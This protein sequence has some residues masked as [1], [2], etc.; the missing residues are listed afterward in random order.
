MLIACAGCLPAW[1]IPELVRLCIT[2]IYVCYRN[3]LCLYDGIF[4]YA[5]NICLD[6]VWEKLKKASNERGFGIVEKV[7][8]SKI[9]ITEELKRLECTIL[10]LDREEREKALKAYRRLLKLLTNEPIY[11]LRYE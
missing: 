5:T 7:F 6:G 3:F 11:L 1:Q 9:Q 4:W 8:E 2:N 10:K